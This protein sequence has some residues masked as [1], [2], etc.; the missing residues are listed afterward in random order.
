MK[1]VIVLGSNGF[2]GRRLVSHLIA[3]GDAEVTGFDRSASGCNADLRFVEGQFEDTDALRR[4]LKGQNVVFHLISQSIPSSTWLDPVSDVEKNLIPSIRLIEAAA[5]AGV[6]RIAFASSGG[7]V[8]G[9]QPGLLDEESRTEPFSPYGIVKRSIESFLQ[10][11]EDRYGLRYDL[12]RIS[13]V[14][15]EGMNIQKGLGFINT[16]LELMLRGQTIK[17]FGDGETLRDYVHVD[18]VARFLATT[19]RRGKGKSGVFN[20]SS[21]RPLTLNSLISII[22]EVTGEECDVEYLPARASDNETV[23]IDNSR[24]LSESGFTNMI[25]LEEGIE[26]TYR[27]LKMRSSVSG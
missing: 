19:V 16:A 27:S 18:D 12:Y 23:V 8:Y 13:N 15:G 7:T 3:G 2:I 14:Y 4:Y 25:T 5:D 21:N 20:V 6:E 24:M 9:R 1:R 10:Y 26:R 22:R 17:I 11:A